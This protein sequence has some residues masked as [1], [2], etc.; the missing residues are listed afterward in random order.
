MP[1]VQRT[2]GFVHAETRQ[3]RERRT[4]DVSDF[5]ARMGVGSIA[6]HIG[7]VPEDPADADYG[8]VRD[9][10]RRVCDHAAQHGQTFALETGQEPAE[11]LLRFIRDVDRANLRIN[12]DPANLILYGSGEPIA[13]L[14]TLAPLV[15]SVHCKD[16]DWPAPGVKG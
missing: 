7:F 15:I 12:F 6:C 10:V 1:T 13:A 3:E 16:G 11:V 14:E 2:V 4:Y 5:A 8:A 9:T